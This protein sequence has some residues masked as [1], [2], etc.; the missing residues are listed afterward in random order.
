MDMADFI[1]ILMSCGTRLNP[2]SMERTEEVK[3]RRLGVTDLLKHSLEL[4]WQI[5]G[6][7]FT[8]YSLSLLISNQRVFM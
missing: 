2:I 4:M 3:Y 7:R 6:K 8:Y 5:E 1:P